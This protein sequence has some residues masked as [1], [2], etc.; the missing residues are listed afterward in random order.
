MKKILIALVLSGLGFTASAADLTA[1][2]TDENAG[3]SN[4]EIDLTIAGG[5]A[6]YTISWSGPSSFT[7]TDEDLT[8]LVAGSYTVE[9]TD[10]YCG[11]ATFT[12]TVGLA[13]SAIIN[14]NEPFGLSIFPNPTTDVVKV[15]S[16]ETIDIEVYGMDGKLISKESGGNSIDL[17]NQADGTYVVK[18]IS[19]IGVIERKIVKN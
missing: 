8:G 4:G 18:F 1:V 15:L 3:F 17:S 13:N 7:S 14:E 19:A 5:V 16:T 11:V 12:F 9:V 2:V 6:P 10:S